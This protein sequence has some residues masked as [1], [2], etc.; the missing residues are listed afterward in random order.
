LAISFQV[1]PIDHRLLLRIYIAPNA[2]DLPSW[3]A[4]MQHIAKEGRC[5]VVSVNQFCRV[6]DF[7]PDYPPFTA[8][9]HDRQPDGSKWTPDAILSHGG[10]CV[11]GPLGTFLAEPVWDED[12]I[13]Y[14]DLN[15]D[16]LTESRVCNAPNPVEFAQLTLE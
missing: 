16:E 11:V 7:P 8:D 14:A 13:V 2:D 9:H 10:S 6:S 4:S 12:A 5:F 3:I 1:S 15:R